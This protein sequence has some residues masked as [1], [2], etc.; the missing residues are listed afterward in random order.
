MFHSRFSQAYVR[1]ENMTM[2]ENPP[3][4]PLFLGLGNIQNWLYDASGDPELW[5]SALKE[6]NQLG[7]NPFDLLNIC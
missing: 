2:S 3:N 7:Q 4:Y 6:K 5:L 1:L